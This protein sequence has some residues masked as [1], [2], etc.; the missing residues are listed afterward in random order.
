M[1]A[2]ALDDRVQAVATM[3]SF[4]LALL[5]LF[6]QQRAQKLADDRA[7]GIGRLDAGIIAAVL[8]ELVLAVATA[9]ALAAMSRLFWDAASLGH[10]TDSDHALES[11]F[12]IAYLGFAG[13]LVWQV[14]L[15]AWR[16][17]AAARN[18]RAR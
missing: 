13:L 16:L 9:A 10:W 3:A 17:L 18:S 12:T 1:I 11:L 7:R 6:T 2:A 4:A 15:V 5:A 14:V 8:P